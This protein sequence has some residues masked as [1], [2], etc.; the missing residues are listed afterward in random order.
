MEP[1]TVFY[2]IRPAKQPPGPHLGETALNNLSV[3]HAGLARSRNQ[4]VRRTGRAQA[5]LSVAAGCLLTCAI[6]AMADDSDSQGDSDGKQALQLMKQLQTL[7]S[8]NSDKALAENGFSVAETFSSGLGQPEVSLAIAGLQQLLNF[9]GVLSGAS[10]DATTKALSSLTTQ[11]AQIDVQIKA[12]QQALN[13]T[14]TAVATDH[15]TALSKAVYDVHMD[16][17]RQLYTLYPQSANN[18][19]LQ[20]RL[21]SLVNHN[22]TNPTATA[23]AVS[24]ETAQN[25][26]FALMQD[27]DKFVDTED[28]YFL[29][30]DLHTDKNGNKTPVSGIKTQPALNVYLSA[31]QLWVSSL[32]IISGGTQ[33]GQQ[34]ILND[35]GS[36]GRPSYPAELAKHIAFLR[37][38]AAG[39]HDPKYDLP[40]QDRM[41]ARESCTWNLGGSAGSSSSYPNQQGLCGA[42]LSCTDDIGRQTLRVPVSIQWQQSSSQ[43]C[44]LDPQGQALVGGGVPADRLGPYQQALYNQYGQLAMNRMAAVLQSVTSTG[45]AFRGPAFKGSFGGTD[46]SVYFVY[47]VDPSGAVQNYTG[48]LNK[49]VPAAG[50]AGSM[51]NVSMLLP[52]GGTTFYT[53]TRDGKLNWNQF[54]AMPGGAPFKGPVTLASGLSFKQAFGGGDGVIY[55]IRSDGTLVWYRDSGFATGGSP[56]TLSGPKV[57]GSGWADFTQVFSAGQGIIYGVRADGSLMWYHHKDYLTGDSVTTTITTSDTPTIGKS[58]LAARALGNS[59]SNAIAH[60]D[61]PVQVGTGW[62]NFRAVIPAGNGLLLAVHNNGKLQWYRHADF[63]TGT[64][65]G[66]PGAAA[67]NSP[68]TSMAAAA[69]AAATSADKT[70]VNAGTVSR[71]ALAASWGQP[72]AAAG[73]T[74]AGAPNWGSPSTGGSSLGSM[75]NAQGTFGS[76]SSL[77]GRGGSLRQNNSMGAESINALA[78]QPVQSAMNAGGPPNHAGPTGNPTSG[79]QSVVNKTELVGVAHWDGPHTID[80]KSGWQLLT[81]IAA[82]LPVTVQS[83]VIR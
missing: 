3:G 54:N 27:M 55:L 2:P 52:G 57:V 6:P 63:L 19:I 59:N 32:Q 60:W 53:L 49:P 62:N 46:A 77:G 34:R 79:L 15:N 42:S 16:V 44:Q 73:Q 56:S 51:T 45:T 10:D 74:N 11:I 5:W 30:D 72:A 33:A 25:V 12:M 28:S 9:T 67:G 21:R 80:D 47:G 39:G 1:R 65:M 20:G 76:P 78:Q 69:D 66:N 41:M 31:L 22:G 35:R 37:A 7:E 40:L 71:S 29:G 83:S 61:G 13:T 75:R 14:A 26:A 36:P 70:A 38:A 17:M 58:R 48:Y 18:T 8:S 81:P 82:V 43:L 68:R 24:V 23:P 64:S 4:T 50:A